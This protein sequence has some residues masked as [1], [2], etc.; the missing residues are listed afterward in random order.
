MLSEPD[1]KALMLAGL[2]G[3]GVAYRQL[4]RELQPRLAGFYRRRLGPHHAELDDLVQET[5]IALH[6]KRGTF[7]RSQPLTAWLFAIARYKLIDH[8]RRVGRRLHVPLEDAGELSTPDTSAASD[9]RQDIERGLAELPERA[10]DLVRSVKLEETPIADVAARTG[11]S[12]TAVKV[13]VHRGYLRLAARLR[14][15][16]DGL[17]MSGDL[18]ERLAAD[19]RPVPRLYVMRRLAI[20]LGVGALVS[21]VLTE[22]TLGF[23]PDMMHAAGEAMFWVKIGYTAALAA[24]ALWVCERLMRPASDPRGR[25]PLVVVPLIAVLALAAWQLMQ[26]PPPMRAPMV[27][28]GSARFCVP[29]VIF[30]SLPPLAGMIWAARGLAPTRLRLAG[31]MIGLAAGGAG[32]T[33]YALHCTESTAPFL[34]VW[35]TLGIAGATFLGGLLGPRVLR[36]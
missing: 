23:R 30:F 26:V 29:C 9:A 18:I 25:T 33:A 31:V 16:R 8:F 14:G 20:G 34:A 7:D 6:E 3:D 11:M 4:L 12:E 21:G 32:A 10:R 15:T 17:S 24:L 5:L 35:Y 2:D 1:L 28:G 27:M 22:A 19:L 36:W 13:A